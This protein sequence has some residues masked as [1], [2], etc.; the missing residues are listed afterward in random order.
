MIQP[1]HKIHV[2]EYNDIY[3]QLR[4]ICTLYGDSNDRLV[5]DPG[6]HD[7]SCPVA[8]VCEGTSTGNIVGWNTI[9]LVDLGS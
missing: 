8:K 5:R 6:S 3:M 4:H 9:V 2:T 7:T 1:V